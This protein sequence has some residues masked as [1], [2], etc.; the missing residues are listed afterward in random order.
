MLSSQDDIVGRIDFNA[1]IQTTNDPNT[2]HVEAV[3]KPFGI[4]VYGDTED[5]AISRAKLAIQL[6]A[7]VRMS[8]P[9]PQGGANRFLDYLERRGVKGRFAL[10]PPDTPDW[11][12][13]PTNDVD[14]QIGVSTEA[15]GAG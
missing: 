2:S 1:Q 3:V 9:T 10:N 7:D 15:A 6:M 8:H 4:T 14:V 13:V 11:H 5:D 12:S